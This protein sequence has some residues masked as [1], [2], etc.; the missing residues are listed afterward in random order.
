M[1]NN[2]LRIL[3][4][5]IVLCVIT[6]LCSCKLTQKK[7]AG[8]MTTHRSM[9]LSSAT[10]PVKKTNLSVEAVAP[11]G[12]EEIIDYFN[13][14]LDYFYN[15]DF[16]FTRNKKTTLE[17][18]S[19]GSLSSVSG[20]T[21]SYQPTLRSA[22]SDMMGVSSL[23]TTY[24]IG[25]DIS[26]AFQIKPVS[27]EYLK[28]CSAKAEKNLVK[29]VFDFNPFLGDEGTSLNRLTR[30]YMTAGSFAQKIRSYGASAS[31]TKSSI[32]GIRLSAVID[33]STKNFTSV[34]IE[35]TTS[36]S[37]SSIGFDYVSGGPVSGTT[38]TVITYGD[39]TEK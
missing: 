39:F 28:S 16:E 15:N 14:S 8:I 1:K 7:P 5:L 2:I 13:K 33:Y 37:A 11:K 10:S 30:D 12:D 3:S 4:F 17:S 21:Q 34:K 22:C 6:G 24:Y 36:F 38:K 35:F 19:A 25:D 32:S 29:I 31:E 9:T 18:Y 23:K 26:S 27:A 20:A